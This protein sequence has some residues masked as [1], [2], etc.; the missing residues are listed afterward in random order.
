MYRWRYLLS[1][2]EEIYTTRNWERSLRHQ[3]VPTSTSWRLS[4]TSQHLPIRSWTALAKVRQ[5]LSLENV[6]SL[7]YNRV[8]WS[9]RYKPLTFITST[10]QHRINPHVGRRQELFWTE[11]GGRVLGE[12]QPEP[13]P[14]GVES[15]VRCKFLQR[16]SG[17][18]HYFQHSG[19]PLLTL[20]QYSCNTEKVRK[21]L[22]TRKAPACLLTLL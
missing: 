19:W 13:L 1:V 9:K 15:G 22:W 2:S 5:R 20:A 17:R 12:G 3:S 7:C 14:P 21:V 18:F 8:P 16:G 4:V 11:S 6:V 10:G